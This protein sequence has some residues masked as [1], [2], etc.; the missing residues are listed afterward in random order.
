[1]PA[2]DLGAVAIR[3]AISAGIGAAEIGTVRMGNVVQVGA[4]MI[5]LAVHGGIPVAVPALTVNCVCGSGAQAIVSAAQE[6]ML[7]TVDSVI[8]GGE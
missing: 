8:A 2:A 3:G 1:M 4:K 6:I 5:F 7:G